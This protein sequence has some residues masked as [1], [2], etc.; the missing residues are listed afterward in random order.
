MVARFGRFLRI[1][2][3]DAG[4]TATISQNPVSRLI[5]VAFVV[6]GA[7]SMVMASVQHR[8]FI[9]GLPAKDLPTNNERWQAVWE[10]W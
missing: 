8:T 7:V 4:Q 6:V 3:H 1:T 9:K 10:T 2:A 5:G